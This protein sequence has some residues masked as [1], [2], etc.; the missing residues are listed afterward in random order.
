MKSAVCQHSRRFSQSQ[1]R[2]G[3]FSLPEIMMAMTVLVIVLGGMMGSLHFALRLAEISNAKGSGSAEARRNISVL[4][5]EVGSAKVV[6]VG[7]GG[8]N[9]FV[10][11]GMDVL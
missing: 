9:A 6:A 4:M 1:W 8:L 5:S 3:A 10:E 11:A 7:D 2:C